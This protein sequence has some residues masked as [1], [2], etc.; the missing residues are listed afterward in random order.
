MADDVT[1][2]VQF[3]AEE[4]LVEFPA[5]GVTVSVPLTPVGD[6]LYRLEGVPVF[7]ES[8]S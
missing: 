7:A 2:T 4:P 5:E 3:G 1:V 8:A 6:N